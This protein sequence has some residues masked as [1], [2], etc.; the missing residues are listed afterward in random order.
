MAKCPKQGVRRNGILA[1]YVFCDC[2]QIA[3]LKAREINPHKI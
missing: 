3:N 1:G 2:K